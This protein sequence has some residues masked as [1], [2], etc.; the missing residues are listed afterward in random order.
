MPS[1]DQ[2]ARFVL[3]TG[4]Q[5]AGDKMPGDARTG[6]GIAAE[7]ARHV[8]AW[9][10]PGDAEFWQ[11]TLA[12]LLQVPPRAGRLYG[13]GDLKR[14]A[15]VVLKN[16]PRW[17]GAWRAWLADQQAERDRQLSAGTFAA[18]RHITTRPVCPDPGP[19]TVSLRDRFEAVKRAHLA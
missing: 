12:Q 17:R 10:Y 11:D 15:G 3:A 5:A 16:S 19:P 9:G 13:V 7:W 2:I 6:P 18:A 1:A 8:A 14:A 4:K